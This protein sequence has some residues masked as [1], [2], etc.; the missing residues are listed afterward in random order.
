MC[1]LHSV[2]SN[3]EECGGADVEDGSEGEQ[4]SCTSGGSTTSPESV[5]SS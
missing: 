1:I 4:S 2:H 3:T 5:L